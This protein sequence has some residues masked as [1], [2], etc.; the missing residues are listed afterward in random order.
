MVYLPFLARIKS[1]Q[2]MNNKRLLFL[3][4]GHVYYKLFVICVRVPVLI[5][6]LYLVRLINSFTYRT[7]FYLTSYYVKRDT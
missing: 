7:G 6:L 3:Y 4:Q 1:Y 5:D 2:A